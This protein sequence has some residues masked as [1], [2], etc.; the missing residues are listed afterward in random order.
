[1][2]SCV[3]SHFLPAFGGA[4]VE[5]DLRKAAPTCIFLHFHSA[6]AG[7]FG[8]HPGCVSARSSSSL[9]PVA[10]AP[11]DTRVIVS[12]ARNFSFH[13][14]FIKIYSLQIRRATE[15]GLKR[16][17]CGSQVCVQWKWG[18]SLSK[19]GQIG[20]WKERVTC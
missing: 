3:A 10:M 4:W 2:F 18:F 1:M 9:L 8:A 13:Y 6:P 14:L 11:T 16:I 19:K 17:H 5:G 20:E 15:N 7:R 12:E